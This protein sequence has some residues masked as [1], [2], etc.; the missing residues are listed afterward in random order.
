MQNSSVWPSVV[1]VFFTYINLYLKYSLPVF[2]D[3]AK[4][5]LKTNSN[6]F[7]LRS[8]TI[9]FVAILAIGYRRLFVM[10]ILS[11]GHISLRWFHA[12]QRFCKLLV[13]IVSTSGQ[14]LFPE[15]FLLL[16]IQ[17]D[18][19]TFPYPFGLSGQSPIQLIVSRISYDAIV[20]SDSRQ[21]SIQVIS[22]LPLLNFHLVLVLDTHFLCDDKLIVYIT[23]YH[24]WW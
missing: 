12:N 2:S 17:F 7:S 21:C 11:T 16:A 4:P 15:S 24:N 10:L 6:R 5:S 22:H 20:I 19:Y 8:S 13:A 3:F 9:L 23:F 14:V 1:T 18:L